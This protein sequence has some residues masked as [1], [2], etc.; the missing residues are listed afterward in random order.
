MWRG[1]GSG[2]QQALLAHILRGA[3][4]TKDSGRELVS[5]SLKG[6]GFHICSFDL[7]ASLWEAQTCQGN[8][9]TLGPGGREPAPGTQCG[10]TQESHH[11]SYLRK[12]LTFPVKTADV[13]LGA[14]H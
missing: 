6:S 5:V 1:Q 11:I 13:R 4:N 9:A 2:R 7:R 14:Q 8:R 12:F 10:G 3:P